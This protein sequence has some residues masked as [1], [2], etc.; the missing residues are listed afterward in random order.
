MD[1]NC[2]ICASPVPKPATG[3]P[4]RF[5]CAACREIFKERNRSHFDPVACP[6]CGELL[7]QERM[8]HKAKFCSDACKHSQE[9]VN[10]ERVNPTPELS[11][12]TV[13]AVGELVV[14]VDLM[15]RGYAVFRALSPNCICDLAVVANGKLLRVEVRSG[16]RT[17]GGSIYCNWGD[18]TR[19]D[20]LAV[21]LRSGEVFYFPELATLLE[22]PMK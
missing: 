19:Y 22:E 20:T 2:I 3:K 16:H 11:A 17:A 10:Y 13:G 18:K 15:R 8:R 7:S 14:S 5:C 21:V 1:T 4:G 9:R 12:G 6:V